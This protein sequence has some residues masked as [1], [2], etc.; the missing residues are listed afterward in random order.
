MHRFDNREDADMVISILSKI[1]PKYMVY[2]SVVTNVESAIR[3]INEDGAVQD[4]RH[5]EAKK[6][7]KTFQKMTLERYMIGV[8]MKMAKNKAVICDNF[9][10]RVVR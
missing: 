8:H 6:V 7:W 3:K 1:V 4:W 5:P 2:K 10:V 9:K